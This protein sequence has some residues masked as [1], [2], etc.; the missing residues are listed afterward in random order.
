MSNS[1]LRFEDMID[2]HHDEI[3][4]YLWRLLDD[5]SRPERAVEAADL[6]QEVFTRAYRAYLRLRPGSNV[7]AWLYRIA[8]NCAYSHL[9]RERSR[10]GRLL[11]GEEADAIEVGKPQPEEVSAASDAREALRRAVAGLPGRQRAAVTLRYLHGLDYAEIAAT[12][13]CSEESARANVSHGIRR[14]RRDLVGLRDDLLED[15][16]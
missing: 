4:A 14:L 2:R 8:T 10:P 12:L 1:L 9:K 6:A 16:G 5:T 11:D 7:R 13:D 15:I 3:H